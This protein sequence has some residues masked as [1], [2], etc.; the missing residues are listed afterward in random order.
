MTVQYDYKLS[1]TMYSKINKVQ[2]KSDTTV[3]RKSVQRTGL[4]AAQNQKTVHKQ[5]T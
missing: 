1:A 2:C 3:Q 4:G 5:Y